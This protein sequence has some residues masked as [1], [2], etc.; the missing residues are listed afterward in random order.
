MY[1]FWPGHL[2]FINK[3]LYSNVLFVGKWL[4]GLHHT[5]NKKL[6]SAPHQVQVCA[7][8]VKSP[9]VYTNEEK[10]ERDALGVLRYYILWLKTCHERGQDKQ[11]FRA[12]SPSSGLF[13]ACFL[14]QKNIAP[15][16]AH[17]TFSLL[18][19]MFTWNNFLH[20]HSLQPL[21]L[22]NTY[23]YFNWI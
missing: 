15:L 4:Y 17:N 14:P 5:T 7:W 13:Y 16:I 12:L 19:T 6:A 9:S 11:T 3:V 8:C 20:I 18:V 23:Y 22:L 1:I 10:R 2:D 21:Q